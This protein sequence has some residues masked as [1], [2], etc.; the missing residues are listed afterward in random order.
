MIA[1]M[2]AGAFVEA[3]AV[4]IAPSFRVWSGYW[5][6]TIDGQVYVGIGE[7][8]EIAFGA[9]V[10]GAE[11]GVRL[12][13]SGLEPEVVAKADGPL[14]ELDGAA[15]IVWELTL[16]TACAVLLDAFPERGRVDAVEIEQA[17]DGTQTISVLVE[18]ATRGLGQSTAR[19][20]SDADQ[21]QVEAGD[22]GFSEVAVTPF[23]EL[24]L[25]GKVPARA[26][27]ALPGVY[28]GGNGGGGQ[29][30]EGFTV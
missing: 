4:Y 19:T 28:S 7:Q 26:A 21:R 2:Q 18:N 29:Y 22:Q 3:N 25:G 17:E 12:S 16:D 24:F 15:C 30:G 13:L 23:T 8:G 27:Q 5:P 1:A 10:G 9:A 11:Q 6:L 20:R 14:G